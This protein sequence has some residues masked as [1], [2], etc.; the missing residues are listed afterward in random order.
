MNLTPELIT[1]LVS[2][3]PVSELRGAIPLAIGVYN[4]SPITAFIYATAGNI[5]SVSLLLWL[6]EPLSNYLSHHFYFLNRFFAWLFEKT[7]RRHNHH[8]EIWGSLALIAFVAIPLP[9]TGGWSGAV[10]AFVFGIPFKEALPLI[11][12]GIIIAGFIVTLA[13]MGILAIQYQL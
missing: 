6:L 8:F 5:I 1:F 13:S 12:T 7:R 4:L 2:T 10:A 11:I 3:L 9:M